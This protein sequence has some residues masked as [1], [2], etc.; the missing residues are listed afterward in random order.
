MDDIQQHQERHED[1]PD[2]LHWPMMLMML[3]MLMLLMRHDDERLSFERGE[4]VCRNYFGR[5]RQ[6]DK[7]GST[8]CR[9]IPTKKVRD[10]T[11][12]FAS[13]WRD[14]VPEHDV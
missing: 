9:G 4:L 1:G 13:S 5:N 3:M 10:V 7:R 6:Q 12:S 14:T 2:G 11:L 8:S